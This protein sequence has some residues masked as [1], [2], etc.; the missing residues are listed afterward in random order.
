[1]VRKYSLTSQR[2]FFCL[3]V[4][5]KESLDAEAPEAAPWATTEKKDVVE[6]GDDGPARAVN[7]DGGGGDR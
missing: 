3:Y 4:T 6:P 5:E 1:M 2:F 7:D